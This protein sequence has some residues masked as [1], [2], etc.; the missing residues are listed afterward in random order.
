MNNIL[1]RLHRWLG[2][3]RGHLFL[4]LLAC[5]LIP[6]FFMGYL[7]YR[8]V[9]RS[10]FRET[11]QN[12]IRTDTRLNEQLETRIHQVETV[13]NSMQYNVYSIGCVSDGAD[14]VDVLI[15]ARSTVSM[16]VNAFDFL[17]ILVYLPEENTA[18]GEGIYFFPANQL[19]DYSFAS[20]LS[21]HRGTSSIWFFQDEVVL[22]AVLFGST[23]YRNLLGCARINSAQGQFTSSPSFVIL[24][25]PEEF[26]DMIRSTYDS[27]DI[28]GFLMD[29]EGHILVHSD[30]NLEGTSLS[31]DEV[32]VLLSHTQDGAFLSDGS[33]Y[34]VQTLSNGWYQVAAIPMQYVFSGLRN[35]L[36]SLLTVFL[37]ALIC[38]LLVTQLLSKTLTSRL[39]HLSEAMSSYVP[40]NP[41]SSATRKQLIQ[42]QS[43]ARYDE[44]DRLGNAF[45]VMDDSIRSGTQSLIE[46]S[47]SKE[48]LRYQLL[49]SQINPHFLYNILGSIRTCSSLGKTQ[50]ACRMID[51]LTQ[52]YRLTLHKSQEMIPIKDEL[53]ISRL[54]LQLEQI[55]HSNALSWE[56][57]LED[58][59]ENFYICKFTLQPFLENSIHHGY[60]SAIN[61]ICIT[62]NVEYDED[63][64]KVSI[65][66]NGA[67]ISDEKL[68]E[69]RSMLECH[70]V[71][72][73][74]HFGIGSVAGRI[75]SPSYG[76]GS[77]Q[78]ERV[79]EGGTL[80]LLRFAQI[81][82]FEETSD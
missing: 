15:D 4:A 41:I 61:S 72:T 60:S 68:D 14:S 73:E 37:L 74:R 62:V 39:N 78:I 69:L 13:A 56:F 19:T 48:R 34:H 24:L 44:F 8:F 59:I 18:A 20:S 38:I 11:L 5:S 53:E 35:T 31:A 26:S 80:V 50:D 42:A 51:D 49:Q 6:L 40:G 9:Y 82:E 65:Q 2:S 33:Y 77:V 23:P 66:D 79:P 57:H 29:A 81:T 46:L 12:A 64:V 71:N 45:L 25:Q 7:S 32:S 27:T 1:R 47:L 43:P 58:G 54:Y 70:T 55:C 63:M 52:F 17:H 21:A 28:S 67:G 36:F 30:A 76:N 75:S 3:Y 10:A 22:P 16:Y